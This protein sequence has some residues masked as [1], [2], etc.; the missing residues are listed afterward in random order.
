MF[1]VCCM[2]HMQHIFNKC[3]DSELRV[4]WKDIQDIQWQLNLS[5]DSESHDINKESDT[6]VMSSDCTWEHS[7]SR[8][9]VE[10][11]LNDRICRSA[12]KWSSKQDDWRC[13]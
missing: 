2:Q 1:Y 9:H 8:D 5:E 3:S 10:V 13:T 6:S 7:I 12:W 4:S 11:T